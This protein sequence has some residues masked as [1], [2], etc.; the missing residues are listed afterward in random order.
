MVA[1]ALRPE[2]FGSGKNRSC[3]MQI[4]AVAFVLCLVG[5]S[6]LSDKPDHFNPFALINQGFEMGTVDVSKYAKDAK[7]D[8]K[9]AVAKSSAAKDDLTV[10]VQEFRDGRVANGKKDEADAEALSQKAQD[11]YNKGLD[12]VSKASQL[13]KVSDQDF[14]G[15][16]TDAKN[17]LRSVDNQ[18]EL[19]EMAAKE[20]H[21]IGKRPTAVLAARPVDEENALSHFLSR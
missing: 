16:E 11:S 17:A 12:L 13:G 18:K 15:L 7:A 4:T 2:L 5:A 3:A 10:A 20:A 19:A 14:E 6:G 9:L 1:R 21:D 8:L